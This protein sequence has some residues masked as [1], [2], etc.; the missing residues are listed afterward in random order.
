MSPR[1]PE[2]I[3]DPELADVARAVRR[4][5]CLLLLAVLLVGSLLWLLHL[6]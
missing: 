6:A 3:T 1:Q 5:G 4:L 2:I